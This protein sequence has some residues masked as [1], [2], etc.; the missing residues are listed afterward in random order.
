MGEYGRGERKPNGIISEDK[1][2]I[3]A[4]MDG[5]IQF[6]GTRAHRDVLDRLNLSCELFRD[7]VG[8]QLNRVWDVRGKLAG[9]E[10]T[11]Q[12]L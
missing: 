2:G 7:N 9:E 5:G 12:R 4:Y 6:A 8:T 10:I 1:W 11:W 3:H